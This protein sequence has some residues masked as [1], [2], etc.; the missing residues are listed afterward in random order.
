VLDVSPRL[1]KESHKAMSARYIWMFTETLPLL[2]LTIMLV[3]GHITFI[4][5]LDGLQ[6]TINEVPLASTLVESIFGNVDTFYLAVKG[7]LYL[8]V[9]LHV[10][11]AFYVVFKLHSQFSLPGV[12]LIKWFVLVSFV[13]YPM[14]SK[15]LEF[16]NVHDE[17]N[18]KKQ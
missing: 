5:E 14:T 6:S 17:Q 18:S 13:G 11:E 2:I 3:F 16:I 1:R 7:S 4:L 9:V 10:I 12:T 8:A 15:A